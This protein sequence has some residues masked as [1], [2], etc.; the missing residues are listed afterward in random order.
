M[1]SVIKRI[2]ND[3]SVI[4]TE[5]ERER[6]RESKR[7]A[8]PRVATVYEPTIKTGFSIIL[9]ALLRAATSMH[10]F[11]SGTEHT[12]IGRARSLSPEH[13]RVRWVNDILGE[14][15]EAR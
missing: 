4:T 2:S 8:V 10:E 3:P 14:R 1:A 5:R 7:R 6:E 9:R 15:F 12:P 11:G 13:A